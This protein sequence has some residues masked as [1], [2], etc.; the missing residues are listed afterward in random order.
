MKQF[1]RET[2]GRQPEKY[3]RSRSTRKS[4]PRRGCSSDALRLRHGKDRDKWMKSR[5]LP[6]HPAVPYWRGKISLTKDAAWKRSR[7]SMLRSGSTP[8]RQTPTRNGWRSNRSDGMMRRS[9]PGKTALKLEPRHRR[10]WR[11]FWK[12]FNAKETLVLRQHAELLPN[13]SVSV[14]ARSALYH[15]TGQDDLLYPS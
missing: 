1:R 6:D 7:F 4:G 2:G 11:I 12:N 9:R 3:R 10:R 15:K 14:E 8:T 13:A 5:Q